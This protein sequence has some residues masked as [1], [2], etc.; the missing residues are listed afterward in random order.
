MRSY[1]KQRKSKRQ[2]G[3]TTYGHGARKKWMGSS[4]GKG[5]AGSGK[6]ADQKTTLITKLY[7][8]KYFGKQGETS[9]GTRR[10]KLD[11]INLGDLDKNFERYKDKHNEIDLKDYKILGDGELTK[12]LIIKAKAFTQSAKEKIEKVG[13]KAIIVK[14]QIKVETE[15]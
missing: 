1:K 12:A 11:V 14:K 13:G 10:K 15:I 4:G 3:K 2:R 7:G 5:M 8:N 6:M 9:K